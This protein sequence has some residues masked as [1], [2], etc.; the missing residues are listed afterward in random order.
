MNL[1]VSKLGDNSEGSGWAKVFHAVQQALLAV[2]DELW[3]ASD[4]TPFTGCCPN[5]N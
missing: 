3:L 1:Y 4:T 2:P 5:G